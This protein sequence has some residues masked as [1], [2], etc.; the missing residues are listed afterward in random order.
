MRYHVVI[1]GAFGLMFGSL[2]MA[3]AACADTDCLPSGNLS[4]VSIED[5][6]AYMTIQFL[7]MLE[8]LVLLIRVL[9]LAILFTARRNRIKVALADIG[10]HALLKMMLV[11]NFIHAD[12]HPGNILVREALNKSSQKR[13]L[14]SKPH[15][16]FF[17]VSRTA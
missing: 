17:D 2:T 12:M 14:K 8:V 13:L 3:H 4:H 6:Q 7:A 5:R 9:Y 1:N 15:V 10:T 16:V 11:D